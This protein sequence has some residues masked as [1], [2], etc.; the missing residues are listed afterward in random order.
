MFLNNPILHAYLIN[1]FNKD[2]FIFG[3]SHVSVVRKNSLTV[4]GVFENQYY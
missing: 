2:K 3:E 1:I 4:A